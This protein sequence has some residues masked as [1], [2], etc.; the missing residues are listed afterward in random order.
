[1]SHPVLPGT[2]E[3]LAL[4]AVSLGPAHGL[5]V[6]QRIQRRSGDVLLVEQGALYPALH[7]LEAQ[8]LVSTE[9]GVS[10]HNRRAKYYAITPAGQRRLG[11][12]T[13]HWQQ[14]V[15]A[16]DAVLGGSEPA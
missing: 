4:K 5:G 6:L 9:W 1:M 11:E 10:D 7:R 3:M 12:D 15:R 16:M 2:L 8:G 14:L 13:T